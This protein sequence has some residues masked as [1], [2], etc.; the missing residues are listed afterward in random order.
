[1]RLQPQLV[2]DGQARVTWVIHDAPW[3]LDLGKGR[4]AWSLGNPASPTL[5]YPVTS[6][7]LLSGGSKLGLGVRL[8]SSLCDH[9]DALGED[10]P[11]S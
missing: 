4:V 11:K 7:H 9:L 10:F 1:M 6:V 5:K 8:Y 2:W 3:T